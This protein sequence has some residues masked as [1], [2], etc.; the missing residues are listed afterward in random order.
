MGMESPLL[1]SEAELK[2]SHITVARFLWVVFIG[3]VSIPAMKH[4]EL[5]WRKFIWFQGESLYWL[6]RHDNGQLEQ[7]AERSHPQVVNWRDWGY[8]LS[9]PQF[10]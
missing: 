6:G 9:K 8:E 7:E 1:S 2:V 3:Y 5:E 10:L 4:Y